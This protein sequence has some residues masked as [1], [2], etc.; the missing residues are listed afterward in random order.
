MGSNGRSFNSTP[1]NSLPV[2][3]STAAAGLVIAVADDV[4]AMQAVLRE[5]L[6]AAGYVVMCAG[7]GEELCRIARDRRLDLVL[8]DVMMPERDGFEVINELKKSDPKLKII[9][10][11]GGGATMRG[12][13]CLRVARRLG[14]DAILAK[15][16]TRAELMEAIGSVAVAAGS[17]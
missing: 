6:T 16:F 3:P 2:A 13:D 12:H 11:S 8:T 15:P 9:A 1:M 14:A 10:M 4:T 17:R 7:N 5:W